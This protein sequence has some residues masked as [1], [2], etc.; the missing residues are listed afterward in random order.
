[1]KRFPWHKQWIYYHIFRRIFKKCIRSVTGR[2]GFRG[3]RDK[4]GGKGGGERGKGAMGEGGKGKLER[5]T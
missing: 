5:K 4:V 2:C 3:M 1:M